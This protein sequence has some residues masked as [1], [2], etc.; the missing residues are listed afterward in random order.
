MAVWVPLLRFSAEFPD[1]GDLQAIDETGFDRQLASHHY[2]KR[3][4]YAFR[5]VKLTELVGFD[6][7]TVWD[8]HRSM[9]Q[10]HDV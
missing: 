5:S 1:T 9:Q 6:T 8:I 10:P 3:T 7:S 2:A 4:D